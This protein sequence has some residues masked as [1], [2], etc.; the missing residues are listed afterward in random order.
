MPLQEINIGTGPNT[1]NGD[2]A[3]TWAQKSNANFQYLEGLIAAGGKIR[4]AD[5]FVA[6]ATGNTNLTDFEDGDMFEGWVDDRYVTGKIIDASALTMPA[7]IDDDTKVK[8]GVN[9]YA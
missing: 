9:I 4:I 8:L 3:R 5:L 1:G 6:K 7:D 2:S